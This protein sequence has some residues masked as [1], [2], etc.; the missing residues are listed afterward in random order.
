MAVTKNLVKD[1]IVMKYGTGVMDEKGK[2]VIKSYKLSS[3]KDGA[4]EEE[5]L[6]LSKD[7]N[8]VLNKPIHGLFREYQENIKES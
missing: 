6:D 7:F 1:A 5:I 4:T 2:E 8:K 3:I